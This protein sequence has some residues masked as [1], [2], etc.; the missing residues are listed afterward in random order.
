M[1]VMSGFKTMM[2]ALLLAS[3]V[4]LGLSAGPVRAGDSECQGACF[5]TVRAGNSVS[6]FWL[7]EDGHRETLGSYDIPAS[8]ADFRKSHAVGAVEVAFLPLFMSAGDVVKS[9]SCGGYD[10]HGWDLFEVIAEYVLQGGSYLTATYIGNGRQ[11]IVIENPNGSSTTS[12]QDAP[13]KKSPG[14][15]EHEQQE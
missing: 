3:A 14:C 4:G 9:H 10:G 11:L 5:L 6:V 7:S 12:V 1:L 13:R 2:T 8:H 15:G